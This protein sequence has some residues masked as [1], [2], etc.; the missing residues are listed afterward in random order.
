VKLALLLALGLATAAQAGPYKPPRT[1][2]GAPDLQGEWTNTSYTPLVRPKDFA[3]PT[4]TEAEALA[5]MRKVQGI[6]AGKPPPEAKDKPPEGVGDIESE[7]YEQGEAGLA[8]IDG[9]LRTSWIVD[10]PDGR[11][12][13]TSEGRVAA[14][15]AALA[16]DTDYR[17]PETRMGDERCLMAFGSGSTPP[18]LNTSQNAHYRIVQTPTEVAI[19]AEMVH[20]VRIVRIGGRRL[21]PPRHQWLGD[22]IGWWEGDTL[23]VETVDQHPG[24]TTRILV[25][26]PFQITPAAKV[27]ERFRR[28]SASEIRYDFTVEDPTTYTRPWRGEMVFRATDAPMYEYACHEGNYA[29]PNILG[30]GRAQERAAGK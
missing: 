3:G 1:A 25:S 22:S 7:W 5:F 14:L 9:Q 2:F 15:K 11:L 17:G 30:G 13:Y 28:I 16:D 18:M 21:S 20:D 27:T 19:F 6:Q 8:R 24:S 12:P 23:V 26:G 10:P 29:L 4:A